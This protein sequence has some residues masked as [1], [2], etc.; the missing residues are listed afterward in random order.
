MKLP[1]NKIAALAAGGALLVACAGTGTTTS[2]SGS[3]PVVMSTGAYSAYQTYT[4]KA[5]PLVFALSQDGEH[6]Y[7]YF[8]QSV[9]KDCDEEK[10]IQTA[11]DRCSSRG[12]ERCYVF[13]RRKAIVWRDAGDWKPATAS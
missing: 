7:F 13:A 4:S 11:I 3:G 10:Y 8:C 5:D 1:L 9:E 12:A 6:A 2:E